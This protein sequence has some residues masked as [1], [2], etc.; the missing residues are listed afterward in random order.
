M[1]TSDKTM[2]A[3]TALAFLV[4]VSGLP[5]AAENLDGYY[6]KHERN[7]QQ[8]V[9][10]TGYFSVYQEIDSKN[11]QLKNYMHGSGTLDSAALVSSNHT[12][13]RYYPQDGDILIYKDPVD[14]HSTNISYIEDNRM[15]YAPMA[16]AY[17][18]GYY[19][20]NPITYNSKLKEKTEGKSYQQGVSMNHL[21]EYAT[22]FNK[23]IRVDLQCQEAVNYT[24][25]PVIGHGLSRMEIDE[26]VIS[27][28]IHIGQLMTSPESGRARPS[29]EID[30]NYIGD[31][32]IRKKMEISTIKE[33]LKVKR[34][35]LSCCCISECEEV[36]YD[37]TSSSECEVFDSCL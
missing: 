16:V 3:I 28:S 20:R 29:I 19:A 12:K 15:A 33:P 18:S 34:D 26:E 7:I 24:S 4:I 36:E 22:A 13:T 2:I 17:G 37:H 27:G 5:S 6:I 8:K 31:I 11:L 14:G 35:W 25:P 1:T 23:N 32:K 30:E 9:V 21:I 10:A